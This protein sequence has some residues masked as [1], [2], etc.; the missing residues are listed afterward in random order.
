[1][2]DPD[3][4]TFEP[5]IEALKEKIT[6]KTKVVIINSPNNPTGVVYSERAIKELTKTL[7]DKE[8]N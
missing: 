1:M 8:K 7:S 2:V 6:S 4:E 3:I 5:N